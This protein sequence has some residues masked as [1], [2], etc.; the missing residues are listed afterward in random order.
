[1]LLIIRVIN[2]FNELIINLK[3]ANLDL[4]AVQLLDLKA[5][6]V[7]NLLLLAANIDLH[8]HAGGGACKIAGGRLCECWNLE[9]GSHVVLPEIW[10]FPPLVT[11]TC[12]PPASALP[13]ATK[14]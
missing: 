14:P 10:V 11:V 8:C 3:T 2:I 7:D 1:M 12:A 6:E 9:L 5:V 13:A 4:R